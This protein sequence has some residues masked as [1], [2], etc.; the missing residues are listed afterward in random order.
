M[1]FDVN[2]DTYRAIVQKKFLN[3]YFSYGLTNLPEIGLSLKTDFLA[4]YF[5]L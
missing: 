4:F 3:L 1:V 2:Q 5:E